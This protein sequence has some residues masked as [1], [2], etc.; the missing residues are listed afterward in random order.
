MS[1]LQAILLGIIQGLTEFL[2]VSSSAHLVLVPFFLGWQFPEEQA[3]IFNVLVQ[4]GTLLAV[5]VY[6][7]R[8]LVTIASAFVRGLLRGKPF[9]D[10]NARMG[11]YLILATIPAGLLGI[12][13]KDLVET[14]FASAVMTA[15]FLLV[16]A[17][18]LLLV[19]RIGKRRRSLKDMNWKDALV[20]G[21]F[22]AFSIFPGISRS[23]STIAGGMARDLDRPS[24]ARFAFLMSIPVM[25]AA[26]LL[27]TVSLAQSP[28]VGHLLPIVAAGFI[29]A[30]V[31]GYF[32]IRWLIGY[33]MRHSLKAFAAYCA[34]LGV[35]T[36]AVALIR[37]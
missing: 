37:G 32:A 16:T 21:A 17:G 28:E 10:P 5:I 27:E 30:A 9:E 34:A 8:D 36:L 12:T 26:G 29:T 14:A 1:L 35:I 18:L 15:V 22:Q 24:A 19:E 23:G 20:I 4:N 2:P 7:W 6:F 3:F 33:L 13:I 11:W 31:V 25:L